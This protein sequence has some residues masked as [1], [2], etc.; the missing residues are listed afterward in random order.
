[1]WCIMGSYGIV[2]SFENKEQAIEYMEKN[3]NEEEYYLI[4]R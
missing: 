3:Y 2:C 1:M 4:Y